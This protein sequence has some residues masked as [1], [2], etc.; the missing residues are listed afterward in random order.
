MSPM[1]LMM[2]A[3]S[4]LTQ[5]ATLTTAEKQSFSFWRRAHGP[6]APFCALLPTPD[7][8]SGENLCTFTC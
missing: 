3:G 7:I 1:T 8:F 4:T 6:G 2:I 5:V